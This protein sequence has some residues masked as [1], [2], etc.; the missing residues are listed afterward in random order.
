MNTFQPFKNSPSEVSAAAAA[1]QQMDRT[2]QIPYSYLDERGLGY[3]VDLAR[4][5][6]KDPTQVIRSLLTDAARQ[7]SQPRVAVPFHQEAQPDVGKAYAKPC[8]IPPPATVLTPS[9]TQ[10][11]II[12]PRTKKP[13][14][15]QDLSYGNPKVH[16]SAAQEATPSSVA[17]PSGFDTQPER[18][19]ST[20]ENV[21]EANPG[22]SW[23]HGHAYRLT[24]DHVL[25]QEAKSDTWRPICSRI[26]IMRQLRDDQGQGWSLELQLKASDGAMQTVIVPRAKLG[27]MAEIRALLMD[28]GVIVLNLQD[29][30]GYLGTAQHAKTHSLTHHVGWTDYRYVLA[31]RVYGHAAEEI[32]LHPDA[33]TFSGH[34]RQG[35]LGGW[36]AT[37]GRLAIGNSR[38]MAALLTALASP[39]VQATGLESGGVHFYGVSSSGKT[40]LLAAAG[41]VFGAPQSVIRTWRST[42]NALETVAAS[43]NDSTLFLDEIGQ[44][45]AEEVGEIVYM[46]ANGQGKGRMTRSAQQARLHQWT[47]LFLSTGEISLQQTIESGGTKAR[48]GMEIRLV[49]I[50]ADA[51]AGLGVFENLHGFHSSKA[52]ADGLRRAT[53][54]NYGVANDAWLSYLTK[55]K[56]RLGETGF[57]EFCK[58][59]LAAHEASLLPA[60]ADGQVNR[61]AGRFALL[62]LAGEL[63]AQA[64]IGGWS[65]EDVKAAMQRCLADWIRH[66][67]GTGPSEE[68]QALRQVQA[69]FEEHGASAFHRLE[70][71]GIGSSVGGLDTRPVQ[72]RAG[73]F[74]QSGDDR[75]GVYYV[76]PTAFK[77]RICNGL[78]PSLVKRVLREKGLLLRDSGD[79]TRIPGVHGPSARYYQISGRIV[80]HSDN[81]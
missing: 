35:T 16:L 44:V 53:S 66:R 55:E 4:G 51:E 31:D 60:G 80:G 10:P 18:Q 2:G 12:T 73:Y 17:S 71:D 58:T 37:I 49:S 14:A 11:R 61:V 33:P 67:G 43:L 22:V 27:D 70:I 20:Q 62:A 8:E 64:G 63:A 81:G 76:F 78:N 50:P 24:A 9:S 7:P 3:I 26:E 74:S 59:R 28:R 5:A 48:A 25:K 68:T 15:S 19:E 75:N 34:A 79:T 72:H 13:A 29:V 45:K 30:M 57:R 77:D 1:L 38:L 40:T 54:E 52:M 21:A 46:L 41:S 32:A 36:N 6:D 56:H 69:F 47:L 42:S 39:L 65:V 23:Q